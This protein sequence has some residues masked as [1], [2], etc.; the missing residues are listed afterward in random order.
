MNIEICFKL[1]LNCVSGL[2]FCCG[3]WSV[4]SN[5]KC[6]VTLLGHGNNHINAK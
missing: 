1:L 5:F 2:E 4:F 6:V 3:L